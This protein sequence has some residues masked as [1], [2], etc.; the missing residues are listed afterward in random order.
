MSSFAATSCP[1]LSGLALAPL[2][3]LIVGL[4]RRVT[5]ILVDEELPL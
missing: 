2:A 4:H 1:G 5:A 3:L